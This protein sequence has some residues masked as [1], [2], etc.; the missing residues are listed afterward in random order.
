[1][2]KVA[3]LPF[4]R[5]A[6]WALQRPRWFKLGAQLLHKIGWLSRFHMRYA[7]VQV[8]PKNKR[9]RLFR[10]F[11]SILD[12]KTSAPLLLSFWQTNNTPTLV[13]LATRDRMVPNDKI[14][15][16]FSKHPNCNIIEVDDKHEM[17][18]E[19]AARI[20]LKKV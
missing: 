12:F 7:E 1:M 13:I 16:Y 3:P 2:T 17:N 20:I 5:I 18:M 6:E 4:Q 10:V 8:F 14:K 15:I 9:F 19:V 11:N